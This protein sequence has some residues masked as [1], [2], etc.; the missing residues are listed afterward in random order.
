MSRFLCKSDKI[1]S[2]FLIMLGAIG[3][4]SQFALLVVSSLMARASKLAAGLQTFAE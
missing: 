4:T 2:K 3:A 1:M